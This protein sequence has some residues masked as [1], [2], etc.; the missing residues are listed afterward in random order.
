MLAEFL[1]AIITSP[2]EPRDLELKAMWHAAR[3]GQPIAFEL[4]GSAEDDEE[5]SE[6]D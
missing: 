1:H 2:E 5:D 4:F 6:S 3:N